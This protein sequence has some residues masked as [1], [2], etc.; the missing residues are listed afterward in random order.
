MVTMSA[1]WSGLER[2]AYV[3]ASFTSGEPPGAKLGIVRQGGNLLVTMDKLT[4]GATNTL[5]RS[6]DLND[7]GAWPPVTT[8]VSTGSESNWTETT[9][10][11]QASYRLSSDF[12]PPM[13]FL[14]EDFEDGATDWTIAGSGT[15]WEIGTPTVGP[16]GANSG[17]KAAATGLGGDYMNGTDTTMRSPVVDLS[18]VDAAKLVFFDAYDLE[19]G[20]DYGYV[21]ILDS[22][23]GVLAPQVYTVNGFGNDN[24]W[25]ERTVVIPSN[26]V[27]RQIIIE[28]QLQADA[29]DPVGRGWMIDDVVVA[30]P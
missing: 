28:F 13:V 29:F 19:P 9:V 10:M 17:T 11:D 25:A 30:E 1:G 2:T 21:N 4:T 5:S 16:G 7:A 26:A 22:G 15:L 12:P 20:Y 6:N 14:E 8:F 24:A 27:D 18:G 3:A 23:G